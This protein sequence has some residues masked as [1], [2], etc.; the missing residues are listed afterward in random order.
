MAQSLLLSIS[1]D[2]DT[3]RRLV[4]NMSTHTTAISLRSDYNNGFSLHQKYNGKLQQIP[5][6]KTGMC[7]SECWPPLC[8]WPLLTT[9]ITVHDLTS[10]LRLNMEE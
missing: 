7:L 3:G 9:G 4:Y 6:E 8:V 10:S 5:E 1:L 2:L